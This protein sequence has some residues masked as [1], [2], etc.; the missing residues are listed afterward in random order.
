MK[1][2]KFFATLILSMLVILVTMPTLNAQIAPKEHGKHFVDANGDGYNDNAPD[3]DGDGIP[4]GQDPDYQQ[5]PNAPGRFKNRF[6]DEN[7]DGFN[8]NAPDVDGDGIPNGKDPDYQRPADGTGK[9][10]GAPM[11]NGN[12]E[13]R[14]TSRR[15]QNAQRPGDTPAPNGNCAGN[16]GNGGNT[17]RH[18]NRP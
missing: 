1:Q 14:R 13:V 9:K 8:D 4:N 10:Y 12:L 2:I 16:T 18:G 6:I 5:N 15:F 17:N 7:G 3:A 11:R